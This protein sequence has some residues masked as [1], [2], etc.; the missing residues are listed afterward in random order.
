MLPNPTAELFLWE[1]STGA[2]VEYSPAVME[3]LRRLAVEGLVA[4]GHGGLEVG[5]V[6]YGLREDKRLSVLGF[7]EFSCEHALGP[8][9]VLSDNDRKALRNLLV[10]PAGLETLGWYRS[11]TRTGMDL[12]SHDRNLFEAF[13]TDR[14][15]LGLVLKPTPWGPAGAAFYAREKTGEI[16]PPA[17]R[18]V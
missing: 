11:H 7:A 16:L 13:P 12:D 18:R 14:K 1:Y 15:T 3:D 5:G 4:F 10:P 9:F 6:L 2:K 17:P 8:G